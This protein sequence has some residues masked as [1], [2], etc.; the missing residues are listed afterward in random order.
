MLFHFNLKFY[1]IY[2]LLSMDRHKMFETYTVLYMRIF[3]LRIGGVNAES[4]MM[5]LKSDL[6]LVKNLCMNK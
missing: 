6:K 4:K 3:F 2:L 5:D 1:K